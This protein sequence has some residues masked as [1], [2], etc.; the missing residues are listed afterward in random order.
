M[1]TD[2]NESLSRRERLLEAVRRLREIN[3]SPD[4]IKACLQA[5]QDLPKGS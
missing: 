2:G 3:G 1:L 5:L 4:L